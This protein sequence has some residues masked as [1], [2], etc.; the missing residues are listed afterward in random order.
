VAGSFSQTLRIRTRPERRRRLPLF[1]RRNRVAALTI[2][3]LAVPM[4]A[5]LPS[6][7]QIGFDSYDWIVATVHRTRS[8]LLMWVIGA[9]KDARG[10]ER[11]DPRSAFSFP[12]SGRFHGQALNLASPSVP[13]SFSFGVVP[14]RLFE[15]R[16]ELPPDLRFRPG[17]ALY[18][19]T[20][21]ATVPN[22]GPELRFTGICNPTGVLAASGTFL[23]SAYRGAASTRPPGARLGGLR[24]TRPM[25]GSAGVVDARLAGSPLRA[26]RHVAAVLLTDAHTGA[27]VGLDYHSLTRLFVSGRRI[28]AVHLTLPAG[29]R[30]PRRVRAYVMIDAFPLAARVLG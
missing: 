6:V 25:A 27:P 4:P 3:R 12:M 11:V 9:F 29:T 22:Y 21:C 20:V 17:A 10:I 14:L 15:M 13:L 30:L 18:A 26:G 19:E 8:R 16:G 28:S 5:F 7:N 24:V 1:V 2:R 23:S